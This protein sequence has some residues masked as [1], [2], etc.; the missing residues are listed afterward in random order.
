M[1]PANFGYVAAR[2]VGEALQLLAQY[3]DDGKPTRIWPDLMSRIE[4]K[5]KDCPPE[6]KVE[7]TKRY[8]FRQCIEVA[9]CFEE[10]VI[11]Q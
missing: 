6:L 7:L 3:G 5:V 4:T 9:R 1:F 2:S 8:L 11:R 10:G